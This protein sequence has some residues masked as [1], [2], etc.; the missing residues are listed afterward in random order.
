[1]NMH[2]MGKEPKLLRRRMQGFHGYALPLCNKH[3]L[4]PL[5]GP[6]FTAVEACSTWSSSEYL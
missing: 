3:T 1:M 4:L 6:S 2:L 5:G